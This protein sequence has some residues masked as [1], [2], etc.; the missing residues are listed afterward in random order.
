MKDIAARI[1]TLRIATASARLK[2]SPD[3]EEIVAKGITPKGNIYEIS[4]TAALIGAKQTPMLI[5]FCHPLSIDGMSVTFE[6]EP[7]S[8]IVRVEAKS[9]G[10]TGLEMEV[11]TAASVAA[12]NLYDLLKPYDAEMSIE[13]IQLDKKTGGKS[14]KWNRIKE[15]TTAAVLTVSDTVAAGKKPDG[16]GTAI[17]D[18]LTSL[19]VTVADYRVVADEPQQIQQWVEKWIAEKIPFIFTT[20]GTGLGPRDV[21]V[22]T[23]EKLIQRPV[24]GIAEAMRVHGGQRTPVAMLSRSVAGTADQSIIVA[25]PGSTRGVTESM[26]AIFPAVFHGAGILRGGRLDD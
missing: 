12:L 3:V 23:L 1:N 21:T 13:K 20:G 16:S 24:P 8:I 11:L 15:G 2:Y 18:R 22:E 4:K 5:P 14:E 17:K 25:F 9:I 6:K 19:G 7:G 10:R 26:D